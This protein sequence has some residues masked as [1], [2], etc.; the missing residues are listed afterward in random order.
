M[1]S[2]FWGGQGEGERKPSETVLVTCGSA[3][4]NRLQLG[5]E[6]GK[7]PGSLEHLELA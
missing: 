1:I 2:W 6:T 3:S 7:I 5:G 4:H